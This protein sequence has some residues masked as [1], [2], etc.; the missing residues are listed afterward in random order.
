MVHA[1]KYQRRTSLARPLGD[2][3]VR[4]CGDVL[5]GADLVVPVPLHPSR[6]RE[7]GFNQA[8][9]LARALPLP[10]VAALARVRATPSQ[11]DLPAHQRRVN[12]KD[13]F[14]LAGGLRQRSAMEGHCV[15]LLDDV[16]T[17]GATLRECAEVLRR[18]DVREVRA[19]TAARA[20]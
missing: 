19:V 2:L 5:L 4:H 18:A 17:T 3:I 14:A 8:A 13:A 10:S 16:T 7:R 6:Q 12:V 15:V 1:L 20:L 9:L 11:T